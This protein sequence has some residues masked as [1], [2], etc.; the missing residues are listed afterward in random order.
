MKLWIN[1]T[2]KA[3]KLPKR[4]LEEQKKMEK[5][6]S[7]MHWVRDKMKN[8]TTLEQQ[9]EAVPGDNEGSD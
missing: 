1:A 9:E 5:D 7:D 3:L 8:D 2:F 4:L 6:N